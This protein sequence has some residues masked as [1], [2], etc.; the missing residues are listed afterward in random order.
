MKHTSCS[1]ISTTRIQKKGQINQHEMQTRTTL[2]MLTLCSLNTSPLS[3]KP[4]LQ[5][6]LRVTP[7]ACSQLLVKKPLFLL[8]K[9]FTPLTPPRG[10]AHHMQLLARAAQRRRS[11]SAPHTLMMS[12][13]PT[14]NE[15]FEIYTQ[16][17]MEGQRS[18]SHLWPSI[19][20][21]AIYACRK[22]NQETC[23]HVHLCARFAT[24]D[25][26]PVSCCLHSAP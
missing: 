5:I 21:R 16:I 2:E 3:S 23:A 12:G 14:E 18:R 20:W 11:S 26:T 9:A 25:S 1:K 4:Q 24:E 19:I 10:A 17:K 15:V 13:L 22:R 7:I 6:T 8:P